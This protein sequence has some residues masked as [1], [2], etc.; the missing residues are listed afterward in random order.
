MAS[1]EIEELIRSAIP[2]AE[3][4]MFNHAKRAVEFRNAVKSNVFGH[5]R[6]HR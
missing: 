4:E 3:I 2:D 1:Q 5:G 6:L